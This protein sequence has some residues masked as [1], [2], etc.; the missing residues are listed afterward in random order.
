[1]SSSS[2]VD[3]KSRL[4]KRGDVVCSA[5]RGRVARTLSR[6]S[7]IGEKVSIVPRIATVA[8]LST[9]ASQRVAHLFTTRLTDLEIHVILAPR[10]ASKTL[11][12]LVTTLVS[13]HWSGRASRHVEDVGILTN[14]PTGLLTVSWTGRCTVLLRRPPLSD[15]RGIRFGTSTSI[16]VG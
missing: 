15:S 14:G 13:A 3:A 1:L 11:D 9:I 8:S 6:A 5:A 4:P 7:Q 16:T 2:D 10:G 12:T